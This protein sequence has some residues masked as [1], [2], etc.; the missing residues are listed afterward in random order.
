[1]ARTTYLQQRRLLNK[2]SRLVTEHF[3]HQLTAWVEPRRGTDV[4]ALR[5]VT[6]L[7]RSPGLTYEFKVEE[8]V[9]RTRVRFDGRSWSLGSRRVADLHASSRA[10]S[11][12]V[13]VLAAGP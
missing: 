2:V 1:M 13:T 10:L 4:T 8:N 7:K 9:V 5:V 3:D 12:A 11:L 6:A